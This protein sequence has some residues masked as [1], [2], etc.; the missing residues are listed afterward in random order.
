[1][2]FQF[3]GDPIDC[4]TNTK[5]MPDEFSS[6]FDTFCWIE[7]TFTRRNVTPNTPIGHLKCIKDGQV[8]PG[9]WHHRYYQFVAL[10][11]LGQAAMFYLP[12]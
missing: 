11:L 10:V 3:V 4:I 7:G 12:G 6:T 1:M 8:D 9:C 2:K 5:D